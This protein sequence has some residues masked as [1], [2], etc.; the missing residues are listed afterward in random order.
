MRM[1][2]LT[3][4]IGSGKSTVTA[5]FRELGAQVIDADQVARDVAEP[6]T[7]GL[8]EVAR[9][10]PGVLDPSGHLDR[11]ALGRRVFAD[12]GER[13]A[14][15]GILHPRIR[16]EVA[17]RTEALARAGVTVVLYD[18]ELLIENGLHRGMDGVILVSA[19]EAVQRARL[20]ARDGLDDAAITAR[21]AA[22]LPLADKRAHA[23]WVVDNGGSLDETRAQVRRIWEEIRGSG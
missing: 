23:T 19:P 11:A 4:G 1:V 9:R 3:G 18:A 8:E 2:G 10:F 6:G 12:P 13:R 15:E 16:E 21:L 7:P 14:L 5:M 20:A 17:R 22:Q